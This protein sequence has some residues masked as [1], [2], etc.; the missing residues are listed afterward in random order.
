VIKI[1]VVDDE[2]KEQKL[3]MKFYSNLSTELQEEIKVHPFD[4]GEALLEAYDYSWDLICLDVQMKGQDGISIAK[5]LR[6]VDEQVI[7]IFVTRMAQMAIKG[8]EVQAMDFLVKPVSYYPFALKMRNVINVINNKKSRNIVL[9]TSDGWRRISSNNL[10]YAEVERHYITYYTEDGTFRQ[11]A[12]LTELENKLEGLSF[13]RCNNC[14]LVNLKYVDAV[15]KDDVK[16]A[17]TWLKISRLRKKEFLQ[18]LANYMGGI[19]L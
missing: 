17:G 14:Y 16:I 8:Y 7:L 9:N 13:K 11:K 18:A 3:L 4:S 5:K 6:L 19:E 2:E 1:A 12:S 15:Y 10:Y